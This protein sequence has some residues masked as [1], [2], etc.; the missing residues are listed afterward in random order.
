MKKVMTQG[1]VTAGFHTAECALAGELRRVG[2]FCRASG[3][4]PGTAPTAWQAA[5]KTEKSRWSRSASVV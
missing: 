1:F 5:C 4:P 2:A 3:H